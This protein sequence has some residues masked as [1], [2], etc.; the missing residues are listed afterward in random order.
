M[1]FILTLNFKKNL[2]MALRK[3]DESGKILGKDMWVRAHSKGNTVE[4]FKKN[5]P[6]ELN[7]LNNNLEIC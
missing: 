5:A 7:G 3:L 6:V 1:I 2:G 4:R